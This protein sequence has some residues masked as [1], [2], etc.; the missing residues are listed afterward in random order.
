MRD[1]VTTHLSNGFIAISSAPQAA[2]ILFVK[3]PGSGIWFCVDYHK[4]NIITKKDTYLN[5]VFFEYLY[6]FC[7]AYIDNILIYSKNKKE[8]M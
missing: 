1:Y 7:I 2:P 8:H 5:R 6:Y 4:L 3:K